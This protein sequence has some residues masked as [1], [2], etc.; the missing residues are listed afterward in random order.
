ML[1]WT[2]MCLCNRESPRAKVDLVLVARR[3]EKIPTCQSALC[4][5]TSCGWMSIDSRLRMRIRVFRWQ[6][7]PR[8]AEKCGAKSP[9]NQ[10]VIQAALVF[11]AK[12]EWRHN[13]DLLDSQKFHWSVSGSLL[14]PSPFSDSSV[15]GILGIKTT[16]TNSLLTTLTSLSGYVSPYAP[17]ARSP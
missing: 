11:W 2:L 15:R 9:I 12:A 8:R 17:F 10:W 4:Q 6:T 3:Q 1:N 13:S 16:L 14:F 7:S 5:P